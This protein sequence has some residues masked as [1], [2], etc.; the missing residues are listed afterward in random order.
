VFITKAVIKIICANFSIFPLLDYESKAIPFSVSDM[1]P[2][3]NYNNEATNL[4]MT[5]HNP[6]PHFLRNQVQ[7]NQR[8]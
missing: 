7:G 2:P 5:L 4:M 6:S 1:V 3:K 8:I